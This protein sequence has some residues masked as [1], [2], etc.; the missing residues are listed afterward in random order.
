M[1]GNCRGYDAGCTCRACQS[2]AYREALRR[3]E[4]AVARSDD[5]TLAAFLR[6]EGLPVNE[7]M[8]AYAG[9]WEWWLRVLGE[10]GRILRPQDMPSWRDGWPCPCCRRPVNRGE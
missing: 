4:E 3:L 7:H 8:L 5:S 10:S 9:A 2:R 1:D 6:S